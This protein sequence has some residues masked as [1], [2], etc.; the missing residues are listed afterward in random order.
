MKKI[1]IMK[2]IKYNLFFLTRIPVKVELNNYEDVAA[3][4]WLS[5]LVGWVLALIGSIIALIL[6]KF[7]PATI[8][9]FIILGIL[10][11]L[12]GAHHLDGLIDFGDGIM[13]RGTA[14]HKIKIMH[15]VSIGAGGFSLGFII[16]SL[17]GFS[18][19]FSKS[20]IIISLL[21]AEVCAKFS[22]VAACSLGKSADTEIVRPFMEKNSV[23]QFI[24][25]LIL[26][27]VLIYLTIILNSIY[28]FM[29][30]TILVLPNFLISIEAFSIFNYYSIFS[31]FFIAF[32]STFLSLLLIMRI[33]YKNFKGFTGDCMGALNECTRLFCLIFIIIFYSLNLI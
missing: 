27:C 9:G 6:F 21:I 24:Y 1:N 22:M 15:D 20:H 23:M 7:L 10:I 11:Y 8:V 26:T 28:S 17:T 19:A 3:V 18:I 30:N 2:K 25:S 33:A 4:F 32:I 14:E 31:V 12:T 16:M 29:T 5:P 13:A